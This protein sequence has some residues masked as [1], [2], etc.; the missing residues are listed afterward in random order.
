M[1]SRRWKMEDGGWTARSTLNF[2]GPGPLL[3]GWIQSVTTGSIW[4][5]YS[6]QTNGATCCRIESPPTSNRFYRLHKP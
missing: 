3:T 1:R 5:E 4:T 6:Y 2:G